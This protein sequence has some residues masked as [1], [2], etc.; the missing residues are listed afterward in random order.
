VPR[1]LEIFGTEGAVDYAMVQLIVIDMRWPTGIWSQSSIT[2]TLVI[3]PTARMNPCGEL[4][5][6]EQL[7]LAMKA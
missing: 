3:L 1:F 4:I 7:V 6:A 2:G 5:T